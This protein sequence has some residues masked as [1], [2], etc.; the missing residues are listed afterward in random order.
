MKI[1]VEDEKMYFDKNSARASEWVRDDWNALKDRIWRMF[2]KIFLV[3]FVLLKHSQA[4]ENFRNVFWLFHQKRF[5]ALIF[6]PWRR[7]KRRRAFIQNVWLVV[8]N[9][10]RCCSQNFFLAGV[11]NP[12]KKERERAVVAFPRIRGSCGKF[13]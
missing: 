11:R 12:W 7:I 2:K 5:P 6:D 4:G 3:C 9:P 13:T 10:T 8:T 1:D